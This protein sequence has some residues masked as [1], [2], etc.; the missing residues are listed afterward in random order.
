MALSNSSPAYRFGDFVLDPRAFR[1]ARN[2]E[3]VKL[4]PK[5]F[6]VLLCLLRRPG[7]VVS[8]HDLVTDAW[9]GIAITDNAVAR[10]VANLRRALDDHP[11][12][13]AIYRDRPHEGISL[14]LRGRGGRWGGRQAG[15]SLARRPRSSPAR[16]QRRRAARRGAAEAAPR[17]VTPPG[18]VPPE[19]SRA[20]VSRFRLAAGIAGCRRSRDHHHPGRQRRNDGPAERP[21][22]RDGPS[23]DRRHDPASARWPSSAPQPD[24]RPVAG[25]RRGRHD[26]GAQRPVLGAWRRERC[27]HHLVDATT[28]TRSCPAGRIAAELSA[29]AL[30]E[31]AVARSGD[32]VRVSVSLV[33]GRSGSSRVDGAVRP[34]DRRRAGAVRPRSRS[35]P[36]VRPSSR[37]TR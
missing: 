6:D 11:E 9:K 16:C 1:L 2:G 35:P 34:F 31:G 19:Q 33:D 8:R 37:W 30:V 21:T 12:S 22:L 27:V 28:G 32:R 20:G 26:A 10:V 36:R 4:E 5:A 29:D 18:P 3:P 23:S 15:A 24:G 13:A 7:E 14:R 17:D 25:L